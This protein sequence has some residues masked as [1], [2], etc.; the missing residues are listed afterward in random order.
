[1]A[2]KGYA[3]SWSEAKLKVRDNPALNVRREK[4]SPLAAI[5]LIK[6]C[7]G[8]VVLAHPYL[9]DEEVNSKELG[10]ISRDEY[11]DKLIN[12]FSPKEILI[13]RSKQTF[14]FETFG[15]KFYTYPLDDWMFNEETSIERLLKQFDTV[16][17][18]GF[19]VHKLELGSVAA[20]AI[21][22]YLDLTHHHQTEH[23]TRLARIE[24]DKYVWLDK[25]TIRNLELFNS[26]GEDAKSLLDVIDKTVSPPGSR[27]MKR[28]LALPLKNLNS[29][30]ER[31]DLTDFF[32][33]N[34]GI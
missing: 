22:Q 29:I 12:N 9:I 14:F 3:K 33:R 30:N 31:L 25:F 24:E 32:L 8:L 28:W 2:K 11:I 7:G 1:M 13:E 4:I 10:S 16:S 6:K 21:L 15:K 5:E 34:A 20:G 27:L 23:I 19:G 17:L 26:F 18:K